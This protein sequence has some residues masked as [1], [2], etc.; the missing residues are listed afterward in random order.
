M[1]SIP[2][3]GYVVEFGMTNT[4]FLILRPLR[5]DGAHKGC[6]VAVFAGLACKNS[7]NTSRLTCEAGQNGGEMEN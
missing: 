7:N 6:I 2:L 4:G 5:A 3:M 1:G